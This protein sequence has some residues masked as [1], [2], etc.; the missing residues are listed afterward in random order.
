LNSVFLSLATSLLALWPAEPASVCQGPC[1]PAP[2]AQ[3]N[4]GYSRTIACSLPEIAPHRGTFSRRAA[5][6][7]DLSGPPR[8]RVAVGLPL[9]IRPRLSLEYSIGDKPLPEGG[10]PRV[11]SHPVSKVLAKCAAHRTNHR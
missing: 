11:A 4:P 6:S 3:T 5:L 1:K 10:A 8:S 9:R 7:Q 2:A